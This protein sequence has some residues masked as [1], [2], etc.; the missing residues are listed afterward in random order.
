MEKSLM[1]NIECS[2]LTH[3]R[4]EMAATAS[5]LFGLFFLPMIDGCDFMRLTNICYLIFRFRVLK[6][7]FQKRYG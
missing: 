6:I 1:M 3:L 5:D 2:H 7:M 4:I